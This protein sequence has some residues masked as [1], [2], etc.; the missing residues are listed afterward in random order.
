VVTAPEIET[1]GEN[2]GLLTREAFSL[3][4]SATDFHSILERLTHEHTSDE[5]EA[6]FG[7]RMSSQARAFVLSLKRQSV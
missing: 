2:V 4:S 7:G 5:I 6:L 3:D 1:F